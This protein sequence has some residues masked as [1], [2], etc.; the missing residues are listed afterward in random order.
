M[1]GKTHL[2]VGVTAALAA[3]RPGTATECLAAVLGGAVGGVLCDI[4]TLRSE[5]SNDSIGVQLCALA[6]AACVLGLDWWQRA[7]LCAGV[8]ALERERLICGA[9]GFTLLWLAGLFSSHRGFT[10]SLTAGLLFAKAVDLLCP[11][12][13]L[14]FAAAYASHLAIDLLN[15]KGMRLLFPLK[16]RVCLGW[17]YSD[18]AVNTLLFQFGILGTAFLLVNSTVMHL[19]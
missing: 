15:K 5:G 19:F 1:M 3:A 6:I 7:G 13:A 2:A 16:G 11:A 9:V 10:H 14:P 18:R 8:M 4:D 17:C 12:A